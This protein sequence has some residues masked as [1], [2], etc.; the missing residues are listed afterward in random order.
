MDRRRSDQGSRPSVIADASSV[1]ASAAAGGVTEGSVAGAGGEPRTQV[2]AEKTDKESGRER[3]RRVGGRRRSSDL[4]KGKNNDGR[5]NRGRVATDGITGL[6]DRVAREAGS[7]VGPA[8]GPV[9]AKSVRTDTHPTQPPPPLPPRDGD[10]KQ[11]RIAPTTAPAT[12]T[13]SSGDGDTGRG[14]RVMEAG[15]P[16][17]EGEVHRESARSGRNRERDRRSEARPVPEGPGA[18]QG[19]RR[20]DSRRESGPHVPTPASPAQQ[21]SVI[22]SQEETARRPGVG[23]VAGSVPRP[24]LPGPH[25][26]PAPSGDTQ[27]TPSAP[28]RGGAGGGAQERV[29]RE[30]RATGGRGGGREVP[31]G[32]GGAD[33]RR[34]GPLPGKPDT[35]K[36]P[37]PLPPPTSNGTLHPATPTPMSHYPTP[38]STKPPQGPPPPPTKAPA[39]TGPK[40][41]S[42]APGSTSQRPK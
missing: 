3:E 33:P 28:P 32:R 23:A 17:H 18:G 42:H 7:V 4:D 13:A 31:G 40:P 11:D 9:V 19:P 22:R 39:S 12:T 36:P 21:T 38:S 41:T 15:R 5:R 2:V 29:Q 10:R 16:V 20:R 30:S 25:R 34:T 1:A 26:P 8:D 24:A 14:E 35:P 6:A 37:L 27:T